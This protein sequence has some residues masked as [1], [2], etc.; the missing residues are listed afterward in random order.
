MLA[1]SLISIRENRLDEALD[2]IDALLKIH[3]DFRLAQLIKG[4]LLMARARPLQTIGDV[5]PTRRQ[6]ASAA[7]REEARARSRVTGRVRRRIGCPKYLL[8]LQPE[9]RYALVVDTAK[10]TLYVFENDAGRPRYVTDYY[11]TPRQERHRQAARRRQEDPA[12][13]LSRR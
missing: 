6:I 5:S 3:P 8:Q 9:Q 13:R 10:S 12:G 2:Q 11:V 1:Q 4:D 7:L